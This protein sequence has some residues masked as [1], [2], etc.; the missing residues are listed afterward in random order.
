MAPTPSSGAQ[1]PPP[2]EPAQVDPAV[3]DETPAQHTAGGLH[4]PLT[5]KQSHLPDMQ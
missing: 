4:P 5:P 2:P 3:Q 1:L